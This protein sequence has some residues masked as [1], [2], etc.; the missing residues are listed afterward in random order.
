VLRDIS[1]EFPWKIADMKKNKENVN[2][3]AKNV[4]YVSQ[5]GFL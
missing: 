1:G 5:G 3:D 4:V 2:F